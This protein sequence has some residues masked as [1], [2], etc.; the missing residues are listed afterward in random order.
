MG[1]KTPAP[2]DEWP[3]RRV[4][5]PVMNP[6]IAG[7]IAGCVATPVGVV[8]RARLR[9]EGHRYEDEVGTPT[10]SHAWVL[11]ALPVAALLIGHALSVTHNAG[12]A[13]AYCVSLPVLV[14]LAAIDLDVHR[15]PDKLTFPLVP[16][17][18]VI[19]AAASA[20]TG[21]WFPLLRAVLAGLALGAAYLVLLLISPGGGGLGL[22]DVKLAVGLGVLLGWFSWYAVLVGTLSGFVLGGLWAAGLLISRR[23][24]RHSYI[25]FGPFMLGGAIIALLVGG[26]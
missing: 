10:R 21:E 19:A 15:L 13:F 22:G 1:R 3:A 8:L 26:A 9:T 6:W 18:I 24:T 16:L 11:I 20:C 4:L 23:A 2:A 14:A 12:V 17:A 25:A 7:V 5:S